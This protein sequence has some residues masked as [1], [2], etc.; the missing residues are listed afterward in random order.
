M[1]RKLLISVLLSVA[2]VWALQYYFGS[3]TENLQQGVVSVSE[4]NTVAAGQPVKVPSTQDLYKPL[5]YEIDF[6]KKKISEK[7]QT[8]EVETDLVK[9]T[10]S[11]YGAILTSIDFKEHQG[12]NK[13]PL[14][15]VYEKGGY[16]KELKKQGCFLLAFE[17]DS[18]YFYKLLNRKTLENKEIISYQTETN[19]WIVR[20]IYAV[21]IGSYKIDLTLQFEPKTSESLPLKPRIQFVAPY[22]HDLA[23]D[24]IEPF[25]FNESANK[26]EIKDLT[27]VHDYAWYWSQ[28]KVLFG[29]SDRYFAHA[30]INDP[31]KFVQRAYF[32][33]VDAKNVFSMLEGYLIQEKKDVTLSFYFG[34]KLY[35]HL[36]Y[37]DERLSDILSFGWLSWFCKLILKLLQLVYK[38]VGNYGIAIILLTVLLRL[39]F[40]PLS[41]YSRRIMMEYQKHQPN[42]TRIRNKFKQDTKMQ[43]QEIMRYHKDHNI[44]PAAPMIGC[45][46]LFIQLPI[47]FSLYRVLNS[48]LDLYQAP[49]FGWLVDL[50]AKDPYYIIPVLM[51]VSMLWQ[52]HI[53]A[54]GD[55]K[56]RIVMWFMAIFMTVLFAGFPA[57]LVLYWFMNN[58]LTISEEYLRKAFF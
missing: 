13:R 36:V 30:L 38:Y 3:K 45:L 40:I 41:L 8:V 21:H 34:P 58:V 31:N 18:P 26:L 24:V 25:I 9:C 6:A 22:V 55:E 5:N 54:V 49:F 28:Q 39:P 7:E 12:K 42:I 17:K 53:T 51:G 4:P 47:L 44:S 52:Q 50:S 33:K 46:P 27:K 11:T 19:G 29:A 57:G 14:R 35:D 23:S 32:K 20:K 1:D 2:T 37:V 16:D 48:Y 56:Q 43:Q 15:T 10:F